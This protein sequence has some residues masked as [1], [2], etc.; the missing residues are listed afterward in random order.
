MIR[1]DWFFTWV[2][3]AFVWIMAAAV[4]HSATWVQFGGR[5]QA[6]Y[7]LRADLEPWKPEWK[8]SDPK[9]PLYDVIRSPSAEKLRVEFEYRGWQGNPWNQYLNAQPW[10]RYTY[11]D[12]STLDLNRAL[13][14]AD[15]KYLADAFWDQRW[16]RWEASLKPL[17]GWALIPPA[18]LLIFMALSGPVR[19]FATGAPPPPAAPARPPLSRTMQ[20]LR[21]ATL[22]VSGVQLALW[23]LEAASW[24]EL[25]PGGGWNPPTYFIWGAA[26]FI[27][28]AMGRWIVAAAALAVLGMTNA[29]LFRLME[30]AGMS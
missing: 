24:F 29:T 25:V 12:T 9:K 30:A 2:C 26:A 5:W 17:A 20:L 13:T 6:I 4:F 16:G 8:L 14:D 28:A 3:I 19:R 23:A 7:P 18:L 27:L 10:D 21:V 1:R 22:I 15:K 11:P